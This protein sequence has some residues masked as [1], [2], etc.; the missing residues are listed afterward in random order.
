MT[1]VVRKTAEQ[2]T[3]VPTAALRSP[4]SYRA[5]GIL[6]WL[7]SHT[8][9]FEV[10]TPML[11]G[12]DGRE[13]REAIRTALREL[14]DAGYVVQTKVRLDD[15]RIVT[16]T[17]VRDTPTEDGF[18]GAGFPGAG[19]LGASKK[20]NGEDQEKIESSSSSYASRARTP[21][22]DD[23][24][25]TVPSPEALDAIVDAMAPRDIAGQVA[26]IEEHLGTMTG[27]QRALVGNALMD[28]G[29]ERVVS[30]AKAALRRGDRPA[31]YLVAALR[32][33][34]HL[35]PTADEKRAAARKAAAEGPCAR[36]IREAEERK[37]ARARAAYGLP[38]PTPTT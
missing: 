2:W 32:S 19:F 3:R 5:L 27:P 6:A 24:D 12:H 33:G 7:L 15:G 14:R 30:I 10:T 8:D 16:T 11:Y 36:A 18:P 9:G 31:G 13:G 25:R 28:A 23:D 35:E 17:E 21:N 26:L 29:P 38:E 1:I 22:R 4:L 20:T 34:T 37:H